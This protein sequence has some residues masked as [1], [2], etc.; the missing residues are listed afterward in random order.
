MHERGSTDQRLAQ[1]ERV[2]VLGAGL[3]ELSAARALTQLG[4]QV[5]VLEARERVGGRCWTV[6][7]VELGA[8]WIHSTEG[9][10]IRI[11]AREL[12]LA[13]LF[14]GGDST[15]VG[16]WEQLTL[17][18]R[19]GLELDVEDKQRSILA[20]D[21]FDEPFWPRDRYA[22][23][24]IGRPVDESPT[25]ILNLWKTQ[26][27][28]RFLLAFPESMRAHCSMRQFSACWSTRPVFVRAMTSVSA[29]FAPPRT[30]LSNN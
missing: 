3:A 19:G 10:P 21:A 12:G 4:Y 23:G 17:L 16:G 26:R 20:A 2:L 14:V 25:C 13:T 6:D 24:C 15:Y 5:V 29:S 8:Q 22:F 30:G 11:L 28:Q 7:N 18:G 9:N 27:F 1:V